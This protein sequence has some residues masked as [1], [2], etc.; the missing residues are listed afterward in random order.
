MEITPK[1]TRALLMLLVASILIAKIECAP[2]Q[3]RMAAEDSLKHLTRSDLVRLFQ[4]DAKFG[5]SSHS[6]SLD[7]SSEELRYQPVPYTPVFTAGT[8]AVPG[9]TVPQPY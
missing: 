5:S 3:Q 2:S 1:T 6:H 7:K 9:A 4:E 8:G